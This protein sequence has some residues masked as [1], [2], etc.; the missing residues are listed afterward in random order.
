MQT[1]GIG[2]TINIGR[3]SIGAD[4]NLIGGTSITLGRNTDL[5]NGITK[6]GGFTVGIN[7]GALVAI[8]VWIYKLATTGDSIP[9]PG[10]LP[11]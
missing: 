2:A 11:A 1:I 3:L 8:I 4:I 6:T 5:G 7:T 10:M 9:V